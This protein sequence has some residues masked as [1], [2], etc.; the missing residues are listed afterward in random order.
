MCMGKV[1]E[2]IYSLWTPKA[3]WE[4][5]ASP[6]VKPMGWAMEREQC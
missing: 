1:P 3:W 4:G 6:A 5:W 2:F